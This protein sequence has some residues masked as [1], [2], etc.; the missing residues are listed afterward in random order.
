MNTSK[1]IFLIFVAVEEAVETSHQ[2][3]FFNQGQVCCAG[4]RT[5][6]EEKI[7]DEFVERS[8]ERAKRVNVG[9]PF[10][11]SSEQG[12]VVRNISVYNTLRLNGPNIFVSAS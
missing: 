4:A 2:A 10:D 7:Y 11:S 8:T 3:L 9:D 12:P 1:F 5:F 6:V